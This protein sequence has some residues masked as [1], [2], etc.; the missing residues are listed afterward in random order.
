LFELEHV[1]RALDP[2]RRTVTAGLSCRMRSEEKAN[3]NAFVAIEGSERHFRH[4]ERN[5]DDKQKPRCEIVTS[6]LRHFGGRSFPWPRR[7]ACSM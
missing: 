3:R 4:D 7:L 2:D 5:G 1:V 6:P